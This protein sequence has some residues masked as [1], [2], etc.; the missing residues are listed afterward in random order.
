MKANKI[1]LILIAFGLLPLFANASF[2]VMGSLIYKHIA[3]K[4]E[5]YTTVIKVRNTGDTDQEVRIYQRDYLYNHE[6]AS[7]YN[8]PGSNRRSNAPWTKFGPQTMLLKGMETQDIQFEITVPQNDSLVGTFWSV[9]MVEGVTPLDPNAKGQLN[10]HESIRYAIQMVTNIGQTGTGQLEF[11]QP[12]VVTEGEKQ[13]FDFILLNTG[14][15]FISPDV[16][17][18]L[19]DAETGESVKVIKAPRNG[20]YPT[21]ST[22]WRFPLEGLPPKT[23]KAVIVADGS[24]EDVFGL[25]YSIAL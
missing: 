1:R 5:T 2:E 7:F 17:M 11:Q 6:G 21:T 3:Q 25:E 8:E 4:G 10:I 23:Y 12:G 9:L 19:F 14:E 15:R 24:G 22:K 20:M 13:F 16:S 18:E